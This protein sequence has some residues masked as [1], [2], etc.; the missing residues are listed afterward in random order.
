MSD[1]SPSTLPLSRY[2]VLDL[3]IARAGPWAVR[4]LS[5]W[6][7]NVVRIE[8]PPAKGQGSVTGR[9]RSSDDQNL[10]R[11]K[12]CLS[13]NLK[14]PQGNEVLKKLVARCDIVVENFRAV[15]KPRLGVT[16]E[17]LKEIN[18]RI[19]LASISGFGQDGP[20]SERPGVDQ[21]MQGMSGLMSVTGE[22]G[23]G[24][25]RAGIA[26]SDS[27]AGMFLGQGILLAL[28]HREQT[29][30][31]Q[32]VHTS[33]L[34]GMLNKLDFQAARY[35]VKG[36]TPV[37]EGNAHPTQVPMATFPASDGLVN[38]AASTPGMW[39]GLCKALGADALR[40]HPDYQTV[41]S[42]TAHRRELN[43]AIK[44]VTQQFTIAE[45]VA[46]LN[47]AR[48]P[49]GPIY[50]IAQAFED[51]QARHM[52]MTRPVKHRVLGEMNLLRSPINLS[53]CPHPD[54][55]HHAAPDNGEHSR[56]LL[57]ELGYDD[58]AIEIMK[59][60]GTTTWP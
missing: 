30:E 59:Q 16:Y 45:L 24:P 40:D 5:D 25:V 31:G 11:N 55:F 23:R 37:Q 29:G 52:R 49:C 12:R 10:H 56:E 28:L 22:P 33:L 53:A 14:S 6:G 57:H 19:I 43:E 39:A 51:P 36:E 18:P 3:T 34:E 2:T 26:I 32:W 41:E 58:D 8:P 54:R 44:R 27:T 60:E 13:L 48:V 38:I 1:Q 42:R 7:A 35:T 21:I 50:N 46:K 9:R 17:Q 20:Y 4:L 47:A 15:V